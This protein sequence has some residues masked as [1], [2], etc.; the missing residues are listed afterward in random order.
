[1]EIPIR[2]GA[3]PAIRRFTQVKALFGYIAPRGLRRKV[4]IVSAMAV[5]GA[6]FFAG[7]AQAACT[8]TGA[9]QKFAPWGDVHNYVLAPNGGFE[10]G[11][12]GWTLGGGAKTVTGNESFFLNSKADTQALSLPTGSTAVSPSLCMSLETPV[13]RMVVR[14]TGDPTSRLKVESTYNLYGLLQTGQSYVIT[15][16]KTWAPSP[17]MSTVLTLSPILGTLISSSINVHVT[18][19]DNKGQWQID[20]LYVDPFARH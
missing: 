17:E 11:A 20:D 19:L 10:Q 18:P 9:T 4:A 12:A 13:I 2:T 3:K 15:A 8:Y 14:N 6:V 5:V 7:S 16:G 1:L